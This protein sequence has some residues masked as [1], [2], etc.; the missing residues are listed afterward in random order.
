MQA[1]V[2]IEI[3]LFSSGPWLKPGAIDELRAM[4]C[5]YCP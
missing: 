5:I 2:I 1:S 3:I 4:F